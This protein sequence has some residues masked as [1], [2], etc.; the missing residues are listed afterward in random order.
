MVKVPILIIMHFVNHNKTKNEPAHT[1]S[2]QVSN[3]M[4]NFFFVVVIVVV[5]VSC[6]IS[7]VNC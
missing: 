3:N 7:I 4:V 5:V 2:V 1:Y 6:F